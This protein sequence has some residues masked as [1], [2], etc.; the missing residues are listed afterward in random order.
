MRQM[1]LFAVLLISG[2]SSPSGDDVASLSDDAP[3]APASVLRYSNVTVDSSNFDL[4]AIPFMVGG[5]LGPGA[6]L[7]EWKDRP[8]GFQQLELVLTWACPSCADV[9][10]MTFGIQDAGASPNTGYSYSATGAGRLELTVTPDQW[11]MGGIQAS[12]IPSTEATRVTPMLLVSF[13]MTG[14]ITYLEPGEATQDSRGSQSR[15]PP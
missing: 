13:E 6:V 5:P 15:M 9:V 2:C 12:M 11:Q 8:E 10:E 14:V 4:D 7:H 1:A 3:E